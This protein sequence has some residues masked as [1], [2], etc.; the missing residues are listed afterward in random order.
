MLIIVDARMPDAAKQKLADYAPLME[1]ETSRLVYP[2][3]SGHPDIFFCQTK[4]HLIVAPNIPVKYFR[5]LQERRIKYFT[6]HKI[7]GN[8]YPE[9]AAFNAHIGKRY[10]IHNLNFT[11]NKIVMAATGLKSIHVNQGYTRC[12]LISLNDEVFVT[13][14][15]GIYKSLSGYGLS[16]HL[17]STEKILLSGFDHG[18]IGGTC[19][20]WDQKIFLCGNLKHYYWGKAFRNLT[21]SVGFQIVELTDGLLNDVGGILFAD[22]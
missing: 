15:H 19:G 7:V 12:N 11:D 18:F 4:S 17:F 9:T 14:D 8:K 2:A 20:I 13:S 22:Q 21:E 10:L 16:C 3:I 1:L 6:G 5:I